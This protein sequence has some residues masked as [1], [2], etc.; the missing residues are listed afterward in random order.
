MQPFHAGGSTNLILDGELDIVRIASEHRNKERKNLGK[1]KDGEGNKY[2]NEALEVGLQAV[3]AS[4]LFWK[5]G[6][7][8][9]K[10]SRQKRS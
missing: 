6:D 9:Q 2:N 4:G 5:V 8:E 1:V 3:K 10:G 7:R